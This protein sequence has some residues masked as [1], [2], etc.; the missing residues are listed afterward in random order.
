MTPRRTR[1]PWSQRLKLRPL[2]TLSMATVWVLL[3]GTFTPMSI[4]G[5]L[6][7]G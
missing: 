2:S 5:G 3:W 7:L 1:T 4:V 6:L